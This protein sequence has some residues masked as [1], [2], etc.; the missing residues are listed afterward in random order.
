MGGGLYCV[1][2]VGMVLNLCSMWEVDISGAFFILL[3]D[4]PPVVLYAFCSGYFGVSG[5][6]Y[7]C[8]KARR[9]CRLL[10]PSGCMV[11]VFKV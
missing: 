5:L 10:V 6:A 11:L 2:L 7:P 3:V 9:D 1:Q 8:Y 4:I